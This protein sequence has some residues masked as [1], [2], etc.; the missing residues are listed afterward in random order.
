MS[1]CNSHENCTKCGAKLSATLRNCPTCKKDAGAPN[2]RESL[3]E[4]NIKSLTERFNEAQSKSVVNQLTDEFEGLRA[5]IHDKSGVVISVPASLARK[6]FEDPKT[7]Y[8]NYERLVGSGSRKPADPKDDKQRCAIG[9][10]IF[11]SYAKDIVYGA[12][13]LT[14]EGLPTYGD[15]YCRLWSVTIDDRTSFLEKNSFS[16]VQDHKLTVKDSVPDGYRACWKRR[17]LLVLSKLHNKLSSGQDEQDWQ[18]ILIQSDGQDRAND[19]FVEAH[20]FESFDCYAIEHITPVPNAKL[21][22][23]DTI[24]LKLAMSEFKKRTKGM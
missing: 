6:L 5:L 20:I 17:D 13:S 12:L 10:L 9:G 19:D 14:N 11:G 23:A 15:A 8:V 21:D 4:S 2:V 18:S 24:D 3:S 7:L 1:T 22:R 16:F